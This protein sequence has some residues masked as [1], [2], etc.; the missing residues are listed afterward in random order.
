MAERAMMAIDL[1]TVVDEP[2][3]ESSG[4]AAAALWSASMQKRRRMRHRAVMPPASRTASWFFLLSLTRHQRARPAFWP[5]ATELS[6]GSNTEIRA[7]MAPQAS[8]CSWD[9]SNTELS[10]VDSQANA[11]PAGFPRDLPSGEATADRIR[12]RPYLVGHMVVRQAP[13]GNDHLLCQRTSCGCNS[14]DG[15]VGGMAQSKG[16][17]DSKQT[18][19]ENGKDAAEIR[20]H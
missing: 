14:G 10:S 13:D 12:S 9:I 2:C 1:G 4:K 20:Q 16:N 15:Q 5:T 7:E 18:S 11:R 8:R 19:K 17:V 3:W 6:D